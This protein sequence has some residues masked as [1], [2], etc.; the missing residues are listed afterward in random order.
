[1]LCIQSP[2]QISEKT[3]ELVRNTTLWVCM[4]LQHFEDNVQAYR[5]TLRQ[6]SLTNLILFITVS[7][8]RHLNHPAL[9]KKLH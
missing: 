1:M 2:F 4:E 3:I 5:W 6:A 8:Q 7:V 9:H